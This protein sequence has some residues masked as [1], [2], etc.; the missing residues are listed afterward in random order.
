MILARTG[1]GRSRSVRLVWADEALGAGLALIGAVALFRVLVDPASQS[2]GSLCAGAAA[3]YASGWWIVR[4]RHRVVA[5][6]VSVAVLVVVLVEAGVA[7]PWHRV[8]VEPGAWHQVGKSLGTS[9][10]R[11]LLAACVLASAAALV[12][13]AAFGLRGGGR[14][15]A[16]RAGLAVAPV[17]ALVIWSLAVHDGIGGALLAGATVLVGGASLLVG[18]VRADQSAHPPPKEQ[19]RSGG[20]RRWCLV[21]IAVL[22]PPLTALSLAAAAG[23]G[24]GGGIEMSAPAPASAP[25]AEALTSNVVGFADRHPDV[26]LFRARMTAPTYWQVAI[27]TRRVGDGWRASPGLTQATARADSPADPSPSSHASGNRSRLVARVTIAS[28]A[29]RLVPVPID[30]V[31]VSR[32][33]RPVGGSVVQSRPTVPGQRYTASAILPVVVPSSRVAEGGSTSPADQ[34]QVE[35]ASVVPPMPQEVRALARQVADGSTDPHQVVQRL[36]DWFRSGRFRYTTAPQPPAPAGESPVGLFLT[37]T[38]TGNCQ[39]FADAFT[40]MARSLG[41]PTR[42]AVGFTA[43]SRSPDGTTTITGADAHAWP[44]VYLGGAIG[45]MSVEPAPVALAGSAIPLGVLGPGGLGTPHTRL[46]APTANPVPTTIPTPAT[47]PFSSSPVANAPQRG[48]SPEAHPSRRGHGAV[49]LWAALVVAGV[50]AVLGAIV[51]VAAVRRRRH[52]RSG[53]R[54]LAAVDDAW[55]EC[56]RSFDR[57]GAPRRANRTPLAHVDQ[58]RQLMGIDVELDRT[59]REARSSDASTLRQLRRA[60]EAAGHVAQC[61]Q[62]ARY[63]C[64]P[65]TDD[66]VRRA[67]AAGGE[68]VQ[69]FKDRRVRTMARHLLRAGTGT[70]IDGTPED[71]RASTRC[72]ALEGEGAR[73]GA[74]RA[75]V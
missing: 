47:S 62:E 23:A 7:P 34:R 59:H 41:I 74:A 10:G 48:T 52:R 37:D 49:V 57:V 2:L 17:L 1:A 65:V 4:S 64:R 28:Y 66:I 13:R 46:P 8:A 39:T 67:A 60:L 73:R 30:T 24:I 9:G 38:R 44:E 70:H 33:F 26:V 6:A 31:S 68:V 45:W 27:L 43:G 61:E 12:E 20:F 22:L 53:A 51:G 69:A 18:D 50:G 5:A 72:G 14:G 71:P 63:S 55:M 29:G 16:P 25:T 21:A 3:G 42:V 56:E 40:L 54:G 11:A 15:P 32:G 35:Q 19:R 36:V 75:G 58:V